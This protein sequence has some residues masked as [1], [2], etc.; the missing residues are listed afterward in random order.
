MRAEAL[1]FFSLSAM[2]VSCQAPDAG[3]ARDRGLVIALLRKQQAEWNRGD[4]PA[5]METY[6]R[7]SDLR[8]ASGGTVTR[9]WKKTLS[10]YQE[11][12]STAEKMGK[13]KFDIL[14]VDL[15]SDDVAL[16][17]G[18]W[19]LTRKDDRLTGLFTLILRRLE[20][21]WKIV[22]DHTSLEPDE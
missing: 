3:P 9:G 11:R 17:L 21:G 8:F 12:Y 1:I 18:R 5:F 6:L 2:L 15:L 10:R 4:I 7:S 13:L 16:V 19:T 22:H 14:D 20:S